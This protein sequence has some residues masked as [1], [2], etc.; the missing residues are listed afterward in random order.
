MCIISKKNYYD[1]SLI[2][3]DNDSDEVNK[4]VK[5]ISTKFKPRNRLD[6]FLNS[7]KIIVN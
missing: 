2:V 6:R 5:I 3:N 4:G 7:K 1:V